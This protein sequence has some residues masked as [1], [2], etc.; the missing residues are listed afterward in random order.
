MI[1]TQNNKPGSQ[2]NGQ[3]LEVGAVQKELSVSRTV[4][5]TEQKI[6]GF[7]DKISKKKLTVESTTVFP[8]PLAPSVL[9]TAE[10]GA[11]GTPQRPYTQGDAE[12]AAARHTG[13]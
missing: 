9:I 3:H 2:R 5:V 7:G 13:N 4:P 8:T 1:F 11:S 6:A 12:L 10:W